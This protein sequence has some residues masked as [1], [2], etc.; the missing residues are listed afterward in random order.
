MRSRGVPPAPPNGGVAAPA[1]AVRPFAHLGVVG[2]GQMGSGI[3]HVAAV[4][5][6]EVMLTD[7][8]QETLER[9]LE[10]I[11]TNLD[12][13]VRKGTIDATEIQ[14]ALARIRTSTRLDAHRGAD[15]VIESAV[16]SFDIKAE[17]FRQLD[18][19]CPP[20]TLFA[21]NTSSISITRLA[22]VTGRCDRFIG[23]HFMNPAPMMRLVEVIRGLETSDASFEAALGL[24]EQ[25]GKTAVSCN[26]SPG[27]VSNRVLIPMINE[28][29]FA[30]QEGVATVPAIDEIIELGANH[31]MGPLRLADLIGLD[32]CLSVLRILHDELGD[33]KYRPCPLL[34]RMVDAGRLGRKSGRGF[35]DYEAP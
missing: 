8:D 21:S 16:E 2:A 5:G 34:I 10:S 23:L 28:A 14:P 19:L 11:A 24:V 31:P 22:A 18:R 30:L 33:P 29:V 35:Y 13:Q 17:I 6:L 32:T 1:D 27:F 15:I 7:I 4:C 20:A 12:R 26:D 25:M 3:A 9:A